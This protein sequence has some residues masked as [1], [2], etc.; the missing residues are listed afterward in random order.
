MKAD[1]LFVWLK[2]VGMIGAAFCAAYNTG[3]GQWANEPTGPTAV[4]WQQ[5]ISGAVGAAF[6]ALVAFCSGSAAKWKEDRSD[7]GTQFINKPKP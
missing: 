2:G 5:I 1:T 4:A 6:V 3:I 7:N